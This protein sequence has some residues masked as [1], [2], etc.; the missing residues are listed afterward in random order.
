[1]GN[2]YLNALKAAKSQLTSVISASARLLT[3][4]KN[5]EDAIVFNIND[6][7]GEPIVM[8]RQTMN[9]LML[10]SYSP[11]PV[12]DRFAAYRRLINGTVST[13]PSDGNALAVSSLYAQTYVSGCVISAVETEF[14]TQGDALNAA[15]FILEMFDAVNDWRDIYLEDFEVVDT[16]GTYEALQNAVA[17]AAG[18]LIQ[19]SFTLK[20]EFR[21]TLTEPRSVV[22][23]V[24]ELYGGLDEY[25]DFFI[26]TN[27]LNGNE[28]IELPAGTTVK[29]YN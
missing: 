12:G 15:A 28:I 26:N 21:I 14:E 25:Y 20:H 1:V 22:E 13:I 24:F 23:L 10:P 19:I 7:I 6:L 9:Y 8:A 5:I 11:A 16:G 27:D 17:I 29:Y 18:F 4:F 2:K 3:R